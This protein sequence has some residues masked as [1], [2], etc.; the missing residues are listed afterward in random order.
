MLNEPAEY[1]LSYLEAGLEQLESYLLADDIYRPLGIRAHE[2]QKPFPQLTLGWMLLSL[3]RARARSVTG[4]QGRN[5]EKISEEIDRI[6]IKWLSAWRRKAAAEFSS[7]LNLWQNFLMDYRQNPKE[8]YDRYD[9]EVNRR[10]LLELLRLEVDPFTIAEMD[11]LHGLDLLLK[12]F[13]EETKF[14][15]EVDLHDSF[16]KSTYWFLYGKLKTNIR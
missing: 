7:R 8:N 3:I 11:A 9:Y 10:V 5:I 13:F 2:G 14:I 1:D 15:W 16:P 12:T 6:R 4:L